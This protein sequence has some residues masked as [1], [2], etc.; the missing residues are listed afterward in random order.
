MQEFEFGKWLYVSAGTLPREGRTERR[1]KGS[2][3]PDNSSIAK[4]GVKSLNLM[5]ICN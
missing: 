5:L 1:K 4:A 3:M 2:N